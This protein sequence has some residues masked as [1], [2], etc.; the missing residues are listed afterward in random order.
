MPKG[1]IFADKGPAAFMDGD[2]PNDLLAL[3]AITTSSAFRYLVELQM[4]FGSYEVGVIQR[5]P[6][7]EVG[8]SDRDIL[9]RPGAPSVVIEAAA[10]LQ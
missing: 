3:L 4:A 2:V 6:V 1:C 7:P 10:R 9:S 5:T 8:D